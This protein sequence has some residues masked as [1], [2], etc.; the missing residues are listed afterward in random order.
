MSRYM[1]RKVRVDY[2]H[3]STL[4]IAIQSHSDR[5]CGAPAILNHCYRD[6]IAINAFE[7]VLFEIQTCRRDIGEHHQR[8]ALRANSPPNFRGSNQRLK[9]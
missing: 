4:H 5:E 6:M 3:D 8:L 1:S 9:M 7:R 2:H